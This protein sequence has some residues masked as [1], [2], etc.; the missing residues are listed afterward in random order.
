[1]FLNKESTKDSFLL[2]IKAAREERDKE[3]HREA[4]AII[5]Q[6]RIRGWLT[7]LKFTNIIL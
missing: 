2:Q 3:K 7:R 4:A 1:M 6:A 5:I